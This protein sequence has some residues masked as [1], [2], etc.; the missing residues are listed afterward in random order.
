MTHPRGPFEFDEPRSIAP[1][2]ASSEDE[3]LVQDGI[4]DLYDDLRYACRKGL[5]QLP[6]IEL[7][8]REL[9]TLTEGHDKKRKA[10]LESEIARVRTAEMNFKDIDDKAYKKLLK[11][12]DVIRR[13]MSRPHAGIP[14]GWQP[15]ETAPKDGT[16]ILV[17]RGE[18][19]RNTRSR[20][21][22]AYWN[23]KYWS[24]VGASTSA[25]T[26]S[27]WMPLPQPPATTGDP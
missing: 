13:L 6:Q 7:L 20:I 23:D 8:E 14:E 25:Y 11:Y 10:F 3:K 24:P 1:E 16:P 2:G 19:N 5:D 27:H 12:T 9:R 22:V 21:I 17:V 18:H 4:G 15:I 26:A